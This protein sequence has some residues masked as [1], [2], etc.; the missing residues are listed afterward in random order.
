MLVKFYNREQSHNQQ[1]DVSG[2]SDDPLGQLVLQA[3]G[4]GRRGGG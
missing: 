2:G 4:A 3:R 1:N